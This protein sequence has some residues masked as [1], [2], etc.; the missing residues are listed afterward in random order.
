[1]SPLIEN[2]PGIQGYS[3]KGTLPLHYSYLSI[4]VISL[5]EEIWGGSGNAG[6]KCG[7]FARNHS[8]GKSTTALYISSRKERESADQ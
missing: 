6:S 5:L 2:I 4:T 1:M 8:Q 3:S 7:M